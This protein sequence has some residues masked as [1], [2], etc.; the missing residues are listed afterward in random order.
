MDS[1]CLVRLDL[2][3]PTDTIPHNLPHCGQTTVTWRTRHCLHV[4][5]KPKTDRF[6]KKGV[7]GA[8][9]LNFYQME[10]KSWN[11]SK[12]NG[13]NHLLR[14]RVS[15]WDIVMKE[16]NERISDRWRTLS[17]NIFSTKSKEMRGK[18]LVFI[19]GVHGRRSDASIRD[20]SQ[21]TN[22]TCRTP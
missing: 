17:D 9:N 18:V 21:S 19:D 22:D 1:S 3:N 12:L 15:G 13:W 11:R 14:K 7:T 16:L 10:N 2:Y 20:T 6:K 5:T 8:K 4:V